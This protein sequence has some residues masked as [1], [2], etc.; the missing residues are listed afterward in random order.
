MNWRYYNHALLPTTPPH[1]NAH[2]KDLESEEIWKDQGFGTPIFARW[3]EEFDCGRETHGGLE[4]KKLHMY[5]MIYQENLE[6]IFGSRSKNVK[7]KR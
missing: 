5:L 4:S 7:S 3:T 6:N 1:E 2:V